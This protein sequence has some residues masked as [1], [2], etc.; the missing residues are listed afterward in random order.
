MPEIP[1]IETVRAHLAGKVQGKTI[2]NAVIN[3]AKAI[4]V[5]PADFLKAVER[6][7]IMS[8]RRRAKQLIIGLANDQSLVIHFMLEGFMRLFYRN[9]AVE[10]QPSVMLELDTGA[11]L[12]CYK[13]NLGYIHL[14]NTTDFSL[15]PELE[16]LG[17]EPLEAAFA[18]TDFLAL[19]LRR[20]GMIKP[21]LM[22]Q[23]F[24]A[25]IGNVYSNEILF[26]SRLLPTRKAAGLSGQEKTELFGCM[27][28]LLQQAVEL[29]GVYEKK[30]SSDDGL[31]G[32]FQPF[33]QVAYRTGQ[34]CNVCGAAIE[35]SRVGGRNAFYCPVCQQ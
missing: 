6:Q 31:T 27:K 8:V 24:I 26:C 14:V 20:K 35:T 34:P 4:N 9:E 3:R 12:A 23:R 32:G 28:A 19:I 33:L 2:L 7:Q 22:D 30:F 1:E 10:G 16:G 29:G 5:A 21:L 13:L 18:L 25:G 17:P 11:K 15:M